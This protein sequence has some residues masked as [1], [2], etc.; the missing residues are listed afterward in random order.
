MR[1]SSLAVILLVSVLP[2]TASAKP[3][4][5]KKAKDTPVAT[6]DIKKAD[7][8]DVGTATFFK[9]DKGVKLKVEVHGLTPGAHGIHF[10]EVGKCEGP[11]FK[12]AGGHLN[13]GHKSHGLSNPNGPHAGDLGNLI[14]AADGSA[15]YQ[16]TSDRVTVDP[17]ADNSLLKDGG[18]AIV[19]HAK[20]DDQKTDPSGAS[21]DR[22]ACGVITAV[23]K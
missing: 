22:I 11:D 18:T 4:T 14:V 10:H 13:P 20:N 7:G 5:K 23:Q 1:L 2:L 6:A 16:Y 8:T 15:I 17:S 19:I 9:T 12:S 3:K 21:G